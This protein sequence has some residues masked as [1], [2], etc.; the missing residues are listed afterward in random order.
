MTINYNIHG[1]GGSLLLTLPDSAN[2]PIP[3]VRAAVEKLTKRIE[4]H[5][6]ARAELA[7]ASD[8]VQLVKQQV[9]LEAA[10][11]AEDGGSV[12]AK[13]LAKRLRDSEAALDEARIVFHAR[14]AALRKAHTKVRQVIKH[15]TPAWRAA[16][17][18]H[19]DTSILR[20]TSAREMLRKAGAELDENLS[21]LG[22]LERLPLDN[23]PVLLPLG[24]SS[25]YLSEAFDSIGAAIG[26]ATETLDS[27]KGAAA[28]EPDVIVEV[29][30]EDT[31]DAAE[32][33]AAGEAVEFEIEADE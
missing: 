11:A 20:V 30:S 14:D 13:K 26:D 25:M 9:E 17:L 32:S 16:A 10:D 7:K 2:I 23:V 15:H 28:S 1:E 6:T 31:V 27:Q 8:A 3:D 19:V 22:L 29:P 33:P 18:E 5:R 24:K 4:Q 12:P 21:V